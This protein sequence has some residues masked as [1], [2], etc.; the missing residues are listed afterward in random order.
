MII[1]N[2]F[3]LLPGLDCGLCL[4]KEGCWGYAK[5]LA[6]GEPD[7]GL[8]LPGGENLKTKL[9]DLQAETIMPKAA[10]APFINCQGFIEN[11]LDRFNYQGVESCKGA[12]LLY[13]GHRECLFGCIRFGDCIKACPYDAISLTPRGLPKIDYSKCVGCGRCVSA[14]PKNIIKLAPKTQQIYLAC[15]CQA[16]T[17]GLSGQC[18]QGCTSCG[19]CQQACP[20]GAIS[21][22]GSLPRIDYEKCRSCSVCVFK[23][24]QRS[25]L[26]RIPIRPT[27]FIGLQ[28]KG[29]QQCKS[30]CPTDC[31]IGKKGEHHKVMR[32]QCIGCGLCFEVCPTKAITMLGALGHMDL[33]GF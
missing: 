31:I 19:T 28:C 22:E 24:P 5:K 9:A 20:Y 16:K 6:Q 1:D 27:A 29:C 2:F 18:Q 25:Y 11:S 10:T 33:S 21:W 23:C 17:E 30:V 32:G 4:Q 13:G 14:C 12:M 26:D 8:C 7:L 3:K 15:I